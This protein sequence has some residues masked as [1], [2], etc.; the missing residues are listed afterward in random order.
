MTGQH[1]LVI[2]QY[3]TGTTLAAITG[4]LGAGKIELLPEHIQQS[5]TRL[6]FKIMMFFIHF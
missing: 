6:N 2:H 4:A 3:R 5:Q 1:G